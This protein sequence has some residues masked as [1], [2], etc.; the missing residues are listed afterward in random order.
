MVTCMWSPNQA[1]TNQDHEG[2]S[3]PQPAI[4]TNHSFPQ[5]LLISIIL[6]QAPCALIQA[7]SLGSQQLPRWISERDA[8]AREESQSQAF[9][10]Y[11]FLLPRRTAEI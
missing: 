7:N 1:A 2:L 4:S 11:T 5:I 10:K 6:L 9:P 3:Q 8:V